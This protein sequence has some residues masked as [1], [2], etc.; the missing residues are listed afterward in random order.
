MQSKPITT[1]TSRLTKTK[2]T[3]APVVGAMPARVAGTRALRSVRR[4]G[5]D[6][7]QQ[8]ASE[9]ADPAAHTAA[10][11]ERA[12]QR[13]SRSRPWLQA[14]APQ[15]KSLSPPSNRDG[16]KASLDVRRPLRTTQTTGIQRPGRDRLAT[17]DAYKAKREE[18]RRLKEEEERKRE[19]EEKRKEEEE[20]ERVERMAAAKSRV[21]AALA[22]CKRKSI[23]SSCLK[24]PGSSAKSTKKVQ[25]V[26]GEVTM[27][28]EARADLHDPTIE[29]KEAEW[30]S[31]TDFQLLGQMYHDKGDIRL[32]RNLK[33][34]S[35]Y[36]SHLMGSINGWDRDGNFTFGT[37]LNPHYG[38]H[39][40]FRWGPVSVVE[41]R[42]AQLEN[43]GGDFRRLFRE[44]PRLRPR[45]C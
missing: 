26:E 44:F 22:I 8:L 13:T 15:P 10:L 28:R 41:E 5:G 39:Y 6:V 21:L 45:G 34:T 38:W 36:V 42:F 35:K 11:L 25:F 4:S 30:D 33:D 14:Q 3:S 27:V 43:L 17:W 29:D 1:I 20:K 24:A 37:A 7:W 12:R 18:K 23:K 31:L 9:T 32:L 40:A 19:E 2:T 16:A